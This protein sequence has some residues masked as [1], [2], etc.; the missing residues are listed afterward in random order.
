MRYRSGFDVEDLLDAAQR[1]LP[2]EPLKILL[3]GTMAGLRRNEI[4]KLE[5]RAFLWKER[6]I[7]VEATRYFDT[8]S[9]DSLGDVEVDTE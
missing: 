2:A 7:R 1:E 6:R 8:K 9:E 5:W 3:L 4:D